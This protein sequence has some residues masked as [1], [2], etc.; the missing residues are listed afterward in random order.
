MLDSD[1]DNGVRISDAETKEILAQF[2]RTQLRKVKAAHGLTMI[3]LAKMAGYERSA[4]QRM[5]ET[6]SVPRTESLY[7]I[8]QTLNIPMAFWFPDSLASEKELPYLPPKDC[9]CHDA[10]M[11]PLTRD[12]IQAI[13]VLS[14][15]QKKLLLDL[16]SS[17]DVDLT[18][19]VL[20]AAIVQSLSVQQQ[21]L[22]LVGLNKFC[23]KSVR[24]ASP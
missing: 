13:A 24:T 20:L 18:I 21:E 8:S 9:V 11:A 6:K 7:K 2:I 23:K 1:G 4:M 19:L 10:E 17:P 22:V 16:L 5:L 15:V 14:A 12:N 3:S